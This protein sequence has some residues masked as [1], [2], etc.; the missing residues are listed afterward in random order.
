MT[1]VL[2]APPK[3][4]HRSGYRIVRPE[5]E[6]FL[7]SWTFVAGLC[8]SKVVMVVME[9][10]VGATTTKVEGSKIVVGCIKR[11]KLASVIGHQTS[12]TGG[13]R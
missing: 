12:P 13:L 7:S 9:V 3:T 1:A 4:W 2:N 11:A 10:F 5:R 6:Q 8:L